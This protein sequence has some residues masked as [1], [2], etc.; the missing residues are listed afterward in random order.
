MPLMTQG[1]SLNVSMAML[2]YLA[3]YIGMMVS[4]MHLCLTVTIEYL[5][6]D[7]AKFYKK[8]SIHLLI[9]IIIS[10]LYIYLFI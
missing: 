6:A 2:A 1:G 9:L 5:K 3:G 8:L 10:T 4:P 7:I